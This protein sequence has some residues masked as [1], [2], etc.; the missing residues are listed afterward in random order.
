M[1]KLARLAV[2]AALVAACPSPPS[3]L[4]FAN[5]RSWCRRRRAAAGI[6]TG[7]P[8]QVALIAAIALLAPLIARAFGKPTSA[9]DAIE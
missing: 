1:F 8:M 6:Q 2:A 4:R 7:R 9:G 5:S 3:R